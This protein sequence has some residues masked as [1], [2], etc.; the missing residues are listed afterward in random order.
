MGVAGELAVAIQAAEEEAE[1]DLANAVA[2]GL[3]AFLELLEADALDE[4]ADEHP[5]ARERADDLG[6]DDERVAG[7]DAGERALVLGLELVVELLDDPLLDLLGDRLDVER[8]SHA[9]EQPHDHVQVLHVR[10][11]G[12]GHARV[13]DL[14]GH[15]AAVA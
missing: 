13:L 14:D 2:L 9:L 1:D 15:L 3:G 10:P 11:H 12:A 4:L 5:L 8:G 7:E 6:D